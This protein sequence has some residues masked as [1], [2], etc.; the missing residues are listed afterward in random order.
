[1]DTPDKIS[2]SKNINL[3]KK[4]H[5]HDYTGILKKSVDDEK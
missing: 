4:A 3:D 2:I 1:M 5:L